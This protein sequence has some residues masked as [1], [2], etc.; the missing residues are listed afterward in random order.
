MNH[1]FNIDIATEYGIEEAIILENM[2]FWLEKNRVNQQH[3]IDGQVWTY[4][5]Q[6]ALSK[7]FPYMNRSKI[8]RVMTKLE[9]AGLIIKANHNIAKYDKTTWYALTPHG[10]SLFN[11]NNGLCKMDNGLFNLNNRISQNEQPIPDINTNI[12]TDINHIYIHWNSKNIINHKDLTKEIEKAITKALK[13]YKEEE[14]INAIDTYKEILDSDFYFNY[15]WNLKDFLTRKNGI[16]TFTS[17]GS[18]KINYED[19]R[20][21]QNGTNR[22]TKPGQNT[23]TKKYNVKIKSNNELTDEERARAE[24]ELI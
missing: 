15:K 14:I 12:N 6:A 18:N 11:L 7:L 23:S 16:S 21:S 1:S 8:Q 17:E 5:S 20:T 2:Y 13:K 9:N 10:Y 22:N 19:W 3:I 4:N 24:R